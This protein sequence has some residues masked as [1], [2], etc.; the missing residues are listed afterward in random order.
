MEI[1]SFSIRPSRNM[2]FAAVSKVTHP[3]TL[4]KLIPGA[5]VLKFD[6]DW[7]IA[8]GAAC[9]AEMPLEPRADLGLYC[10]IKLNRQ[11]L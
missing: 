5:G 10:E 1:V 9:V 7:E 8:W 4:I 2:G 3:V 11:I 6:P